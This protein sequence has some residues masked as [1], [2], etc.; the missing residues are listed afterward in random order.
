MILN[1]IQK[2]QIKKQFEK[3]T[4]DVELIV[5]TQENECQF[6]KDTRELVLELGSLSMKI[7]T[8][9]YDFVKNGECFC[10]YNL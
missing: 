7:K 10:T 6:C 2:E 4:G 5:F 9:V 1:D 3:L 8:K